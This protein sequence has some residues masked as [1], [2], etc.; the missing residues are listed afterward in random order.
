MLF[1]MCWQPPVMSGAK[2][3]VLSLKTVR[4]RDAEP[5][6]PGV[7]AGHFGERSE[8]HERQRDVTRWLGG[9]TAGF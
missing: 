7:N 2:R 1:H 3:R 9:F 6:P 8:P 5:E 4:G